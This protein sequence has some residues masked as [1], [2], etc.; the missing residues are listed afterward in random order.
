MTRAEELEQQMHAA[1]DKALSAF[2]L[3][4]TLCCK[5]RRE[6]SNS[7]DTAAVQTSLAGRWLWLA[8]FKD[9]ETERRCTD[10]GLVCLE[11]AVNALGF[12][13]VR[14]KKPRPQAENAEDE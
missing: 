14:S 8:R 7:I 5:E 4:R 11:N 6:A 2:S 3:H 9:E 1:L 10:V 12:D 13:L